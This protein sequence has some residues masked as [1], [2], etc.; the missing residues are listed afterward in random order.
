MCALYRGAALEVGER[1]NLPYPHDD[2]RRV[3]AHLQH[4]HTL[5]RDAK[6]IY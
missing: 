3:F 2:D 6:E 5:P 4:V 1:C